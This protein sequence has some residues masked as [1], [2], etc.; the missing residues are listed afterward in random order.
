MQLN[1]VT[2]IPTPL[3]VTK[4]PLS[5]G[6]SYQHKNMSFNVEA[7]SVLLINTT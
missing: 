5:H 3:V 4:A 2:S 7:T 6:L 1:N